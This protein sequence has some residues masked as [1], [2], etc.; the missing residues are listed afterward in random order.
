MV[1]IKTSKWKPAEDGG[2]DGYSNISIDSS[3]RNRKENKMTS[4]LKN[5]KFKASA[6]CEIQRQTNDTQWVFLSRVL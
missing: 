2:K 4:I 3:L 5:L 6:D 1:N